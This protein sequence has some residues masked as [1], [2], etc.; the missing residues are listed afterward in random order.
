MLAVRVPVEEL[1]ALTTLQVAAW[2]TKKIVARRASLVQLVL[3][4]PLSKTCA[5]KRY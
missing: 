4:S 3:E 2:V 1:L 5:D